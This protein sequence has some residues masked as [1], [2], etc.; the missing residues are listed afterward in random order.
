ML[1]EFDVPKRPVWPAMRNGLSRRCPQC[2]TGKIFEG[3]NKVLPTCSHC[4]LELHHQRADDAP[5]YFTILI[6]GHIIATSLVILEALAHPP[7]WVHMVIWIPL[8]IGLSLFLLP[9]VKGALI[10]LQWA[11]RMHGFGE[12]VPA[13]AYVEPEPWT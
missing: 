8:C 2:G 1:D 9:R 12:D 7:V 13:V 5:A 3:Y 4:G 6:V 10:G 11:L